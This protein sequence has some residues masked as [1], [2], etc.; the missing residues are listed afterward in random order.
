[1][2]SL[3][4]E[5][6]T[7]RKERDARRR[8]ISNIYN[9]V[10]IYM[11]PR[12][13]MKRLR[14]K[15]EGGVAES[16]IRS[17]NLVGDI[18]NII[19]HYA[20][21]IVD[22]VSL[23]RTN[24]VH[25][26]YSQIDSFFHAII[27]E[28]MNYEQSFYKASTNECIQDIVNSLVHSKPDARNVFIFEMIN[29]CCLMAYHRFVPTPPSPPNV[30]TSII[31]HRF[32]DYTGRIRDAYLF[33]YNAATK[34]KESVIKITDYLKEEDTKNG[35]R[36]IILGEGR[37]T[38]S[39]AFPKNSELP[40]D[41]L[42]WSEFRVVNKDTALASTYVINNDTSTVQY[43]P[44]YLID[45]NP[46]YRIVFF[47]MKPESKYTPSLASIKHIRLNQDLLKC[48]DI[49]AG[50]YGVLKHD[51]FAKGLTNFTEKVKASSSFLEI[52]Y[53]NL[54]Q[55]MFDMVRDLIKRYI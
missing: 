55:K 2:M 14:E 29:T 28:R 18:L 17:E 16:V 7:T 50:Q 43:L 27:K 35:D 20:D 4:R 12:S 44:Q 33:H 46:D 40:S 39:W 6:R 31:S 53:A 41:L 8:T 9:H 37:S 49:K 51:M 48:F 1:M 52:V 22:I 3:I 23:L 21:S 45:N 30:Y 47:I 38:I 54:F 32:S 24:K 10:S 11:E 13:G 36:Q 5:N 15:E 34:T 26:S 19:S 42:K 25:Y